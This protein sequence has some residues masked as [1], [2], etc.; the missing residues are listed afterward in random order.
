MSGPILVTGLSPDATAEL[1]AALSRWGPV[2]RVP[3]LRLGMQ[4]AQRRR[5]ALLRASSSA[6]VC[7]RVYQ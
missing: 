5:W 2:E 6:S 3:D 4:E 1:A 7:V